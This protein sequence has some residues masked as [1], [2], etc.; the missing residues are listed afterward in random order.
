MGNLP[1]LG[2]TSLLKIRRI[3][4]K[5]LCRPS[6]IES[7]RRQPLLID[8]FE[9]IGLRQTKSLSFLF[10]VESGIDVLAEQGAG[11]VAQ[12]SSIV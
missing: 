4:D 5:V 10:A 2:K 7:A 3:C 12:V 8:R 11:L 1:A 9:T 6:C